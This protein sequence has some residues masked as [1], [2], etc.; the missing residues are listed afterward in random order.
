MQLANC[1]RPWFLLLP[2]RLGLDRRQVSE[3]IGSHNLRRAVGAA[4]TYGL[5][6][7]CALGAVL[8]L[9]PGPYDQGHPA[10]PL[11]LNAAMMGVNLAD[12]LAAFAAASHAKRTQPGR[13]A[14]RHYGKQAGPSNTLEPPVRL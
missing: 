7:G 8:A 2:L 6:V 11:R 9:S 14:V 10:L 4:L 13:I 12:F 5:A 1:G 3:S